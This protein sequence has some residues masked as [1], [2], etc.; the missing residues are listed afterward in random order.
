MSEQER[1]ELRLPPTGQP[2]VEGHGKV[3]L[4]DQEEAPQDPDVPQA[5]E[6]GG[7][8]EEPGTEGHGITGKF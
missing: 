1:E 2:D 6:Q 4:G 3:R 5:D 7:R 8:E